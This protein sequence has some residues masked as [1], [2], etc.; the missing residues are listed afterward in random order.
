MGHRKITD[1][2]MGEQIAVTDSPSKRKV[3]PPPVQTGEMTMEQTTARPKKRLGAYGALFATAIL[4][5]TF[6]LGSGAITM[7]VSAASGG[8]VDMELVPGYR[9][10]TYVLDP[11]QTSQRFDAIGMWN[12]IGSVTFD[13]SLMVMGENQGANLTI[14]ETAAL[15]DS[16]YFETK[17]KAS[18]ITANV[19]MTLD[20]FS[21][22]NMASIGLAADGSIAATYY[23]G[24]AVKIVTLA[25]AYEADKF[26]LLAIE[27][28]ADSVVFSASY[29]NGTLI[30]SSVVTDC[31]L[32]AASIDAVIIKN[33]AAATTGYADYY[34]GSS[35]RTA[36]T[37]T[38]Y[39]TAD[40]N[41]TPTALDTYQKMEI[42]FGAEGMVP[43]SYSSDA[44]VHEAYSYQDAGKSIV[45]DRYLNKTDFGEILA[46]EKET[47]NPVRGLAKYMGWKNLQ[48]DNERVLAD[49]I[50]SVHKVPIDQVRVIDYYM[51]SCQVNYTWTPELAADVNDAWYSSVK[52]MGAGLGAEIKY[53]DKDMS[54][55]LSFGRTAPMETF[56][57]YDDV[58]YLF[59][60][61]TASTS[62]FGEKMETLQ[63]YLRYHT[64]GA[65]MMVPLSFGNIT[66]TATL[67]MT[68]EGAMES[69]IWYNTMKGLDSAFQFT[70]ALLGQILQ[71]AKYMA[72]DLTSVQSSMSWT[73]M[74]NGKLLESPLTM[75][76]EMGNF[77]FPIVIVVVIIAIVAVILL[78]VFG[79][80]KVRGKRK[81]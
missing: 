65:A 2:R 1:G 60:P 53:A 10:V 18:A 6:V 45:N 46:V 17:L 7:E 8:D 13:D 4:M 55:A 21:S 27:F 23:D 68:A 12:A 50:A 52:E 69:N 40:L 61:T 76:T 24:T 47:D 44:F 34:F 15:D 11:V 9:D 67:S 31:E 57:E 77:V 5:M 26:Y 73:V 33:V 37:P 54:K 58:E 30:E 38:T 28:A 16:T 56:H 48:A 62:V 19:S 78:G 80:K 59:F 14:A 32:T 70:D 49:Y 81:A 64:V 79:T 39:E 74:E 25:A 75:V 3:V 71:N 36:F 51:S 66:D 41:A 63:D 29:D 72:M 20:K 35:E 42:D 22:S 43:G